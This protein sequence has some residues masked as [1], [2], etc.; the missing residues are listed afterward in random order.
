MKKTK[1]FKTKR[2]E[3]NGIV[4]YFFKALHV[5]RMSGLL[6]EDSWILTTASTF[7]LVQ[8]VVLFKVYEDSSP[9]CG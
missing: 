4:L 1:S 7:N 3:K 9:D 2:I 8:W 6:R 5:F